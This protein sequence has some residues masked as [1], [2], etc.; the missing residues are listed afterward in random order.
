MLSLMEEEVATN[1]ALM[2]YIRDLAGRDQQALSEGEMLIEPFPALTSGGWNLMRADLPRWM[3]HH[4][5]VLAR[6]RSGA[7]AAGQLNQLML[8]RES[9]KVN[10]R[11][12][13]QFIATMQDYDDAIVEKIE[14]VEKATRALQRELWEMESALGIKPRSGSEPPG[15]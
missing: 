12:S 2:Q 1:L 7:I 9:Y 10:R 6:F 14:L 11:S 4:S 8:N 3:P 13:P 15:A 5:S